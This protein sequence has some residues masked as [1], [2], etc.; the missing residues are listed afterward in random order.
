[1]SLVAGF[2]L[3]IAGILALFVKPAPALRATATRLAA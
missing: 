3:I 1:V 2:L